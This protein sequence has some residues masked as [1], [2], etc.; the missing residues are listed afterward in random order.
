[1]IDLASSLSP[2]RPLVLVGAGNM[3]FALLSRWV[4]SG[5]DPRAIS[6]IDPSPR[7][8]SLAWLERSSVVTHTAVPSGLVAAVVVVAV[9]PQ[10]IDDVLPDLRSLFDNETLLLSVAAGTRIAALEEG[11]GASS[12][13]RTIPNTPAQLGRGIT[14]CLANSAVSAAGKAL[15]ENLMSAV[16]EVVWVEH[17]GL[18]DIATAVSGS[19]PA[20]VFLL[21]EALAEA[22]VAAGLD[23][24]TAERLA[25]ATVSGG[26]ELLHQSRDSASQLRKNVTSPNGTT[27]AALEI[28]MADDGLAKLLTRAVAAAA[29]RSRE[30]SD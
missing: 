24:G 2:Q 14:A 7:P 6:V 8:D 20:Y 22:G 26:G 5:I 16:G 15:A 17:E 29:R 4:D 19:G 23:A 12:V 25:R 13:V 18:I 1:M 27:A 9:K 10:I 3:G 11:A 30:L 21:A 28:L